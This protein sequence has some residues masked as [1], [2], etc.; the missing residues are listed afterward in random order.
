MKRH[1]IRILAIAL[2]LAST[3]L[4]AQQRP[5]VFIHGFASTA[6]TWDQTRFALQAVYGV[7][8]PQFATTTLFLSGID[9]QAQDVFNYLKSSGALSLGQPIAVG[10]SM[11]GVI[12][13]HLSHLTPLGGIF[14]VG[15]PNL[16]AP[17]AASEW[18]ITDRAAEMAAL[19]APIALVGSCDYWDPDYW[20]SYCPF[21]PTFMLRAAS[22]ATGALLAADA[23]ILTGQNS[24]SDLQPSSAEISYY[25]NSNMGGGMTSSQ[26]GAQVQMAAG[27]LGGPL[28]LAEDQ[29]YSDADG[30]QILEK[31][32]EM[33]QWSEVIFDSLIGDGDPSYW[34]LKGAAAGAL[35]QLGLWMLLFNRDWTNLVGGYPHD[36][37]IATAYQ[38]YPAPG[39][40]L[41]IYGPQHTQEIDDGSVRSGIATFIHGIH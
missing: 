28:V 1:R 37:F 2:A 26:L 13:R 39:V 38:A 27:Y 4:D 12:A 19:I 32:F 30:D 11:G 6:S 10:H 40:P 31:G 5:V 24:V 23:F 22:L 18:W 7:T 25:L 14:T 35:D 33:L 36:G 34:Y 9:G 3:P 16:G 20:G 8:N 41:A 17:I 21:D 29:Y 15:S